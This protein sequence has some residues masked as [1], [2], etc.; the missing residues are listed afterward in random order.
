V[1][2]QQEQVQLLLKHLGIL[3]V[4][5]VLLTQNTNEDIFSGSA[6]T[7]N[8]TVKI[9]QGCISDATSVTINAQPAD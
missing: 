4:L 9:Q 1:I 2:W 8:V 7:Y 3:I 5:M 6:G